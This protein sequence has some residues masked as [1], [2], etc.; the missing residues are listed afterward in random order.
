MIAV[1]HALNVAFGNVA[2]IEQHLADGDDG[3]IAGCGFASGADV[4]LTEDFVL[5]SSAFFLKNSAMRGLLSDSCAECSM[6]RYDPTVWLL[7]NSKY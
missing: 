7:E 3:F 2:G 6:D 1:E 5:G 4:F